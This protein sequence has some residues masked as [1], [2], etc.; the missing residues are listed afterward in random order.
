MMTLMS[1]S[2]SWMTFNSISLQSLKEVITKLKPFPSPHDIIHPRYLKQII[3]IVGSGL[4]SLLN[5]CLQS[6]FIPDSL[7]TATVTPVLKKPSLDASI[8]ANFQPVSVLPFISKVMEKIVSLQLQS[9]LTN[10]HIYE[11]F[12]SGFKSLHSTETA[13]VRAL[14]DILMATDSGDSVILVMLDLSSAFDTVDHEI[15]ISRMESYVG[16]GGRGLNWFKSFLTNRT[17]SV[18]I[19]NFTSSLR[20]LTCGV[21]VYLRGLFLHLLSFLSIYFPWVHL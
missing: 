10:N 8:L 4:V 18:K 17:L 12:Q 21:L 14:N 5:K 3:D 6:G 2:A 7:K 9:F 15:L 11:T 13:L 20:K 16:L 19:G 1:P